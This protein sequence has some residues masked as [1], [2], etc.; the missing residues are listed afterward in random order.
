MLWRSGVAFAWHC[1]CLRLL[2][3]KVI[4]M[5]AG[6][7]GK[8]LKYAA[9]LFVVVVV[10]VRVTEVVSSIVSRFVVPSI[11]WCNVMVSS[12]AAS[13]CLPAASVAGQLSI[14]GDV[15]NRGQAEGWAEAG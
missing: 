1:T 12:A 4:L 11:N 7:H 15:V 9:D 14:A 5:I 3:S 2:D 10:P 6:N 8:M 13:C